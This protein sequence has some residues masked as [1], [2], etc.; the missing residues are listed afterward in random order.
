[1]LQGLGTVMWAA[2]GS[3]HGTAAAPRPPPPSFLY[4]WYKAQSLKSPAAGGRWGVLA[5]QEGGGGERDSWG[6]HGDSGVKEDRGTQR[7]RLTCA[8]PTSTPTPHPPVLPPERGEPRARSAALHRSRLQPGHSKTA[9]V[10]PSRCGLSPGRG[11]RLCT[12]TGLRPP[13]GGEGRAT[14]GEGAVQRGRGPGTSRR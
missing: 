6:L 12:G 9:P 2:A 3:Q 11:T 5:E 4:H 7:G 1:M 13:R 8:K 10:S 14:A